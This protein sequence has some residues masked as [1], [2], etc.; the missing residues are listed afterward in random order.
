MYMG[1][2]TDESGGRI[3]STELSFLQI[4]LSL[5]QVDTKLASIPIC[6]QPYNIF[7]KIDH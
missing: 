6:L 5:C 4:S 2:L 1:L 3:F 7:K